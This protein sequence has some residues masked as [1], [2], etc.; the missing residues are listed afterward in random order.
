MVHLVGVGAGAPAVRT[1]VAGLALAA[2]VL[3]G[4]WL[5]WRSPKLGVERS[6]G[7]VLLALV[8]LGPILWPW[9]LT[10]ALAVLAPTAGRW[11]RRA[12]II[13]AIGGSLVGAPDVRN[14]VHAFTATS[15]PGELLLLVALVALA[16]A[17][18]RRKDA[19]HL[20]R[21]GAA[22]APRDCALPRWGPTK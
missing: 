4:G 21:M 12:V 16:F 15:V 8:L 22:L 17:P 6:L 5:L 19:P 10:W 7:L 14:A 18:F 1:V 2:V 20:E 3:L 13:L 9:Y 11:T